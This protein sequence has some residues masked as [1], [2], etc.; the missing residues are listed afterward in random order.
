M[1]KVTRKSIINVLST[2]DTIFGLVAEAVETDAET[3][4]AV[5]NKWNAALTK[6][7]T[8]KVDEAKVAMINDIVAYVIASDTPV[9]AKTIN[10]KF[11]HSEKTNKASALLRQA[12][13]E[14]Y[15]SRDKVRKNASFEY[16]SND[17]DWESYIAEYDAKIA[18]KAAARIAR[19]N[20]NRS[21]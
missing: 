20:A 15:I 2:N 13:A 14:G 19:A 4:H 3:L 17:F 16:A 7:T 12:V 10:E 5:L 9:T 21:N 11:V 1:T 8:K 18:E 6:P